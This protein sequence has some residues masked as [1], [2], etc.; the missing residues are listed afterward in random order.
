[1]LSKPQ[2]FDLGLY[3]ICCI[4]L[5]GFACCWFAGIIEL[6]PKPRLNFYLCPSQINFVIIII[7]ILIWNWGLGLRHWKFGIII[8][9][10]GWGLGLGSGIKVDWGIRIGDWM[11]DWVWGLGSR[12]GDWDWIL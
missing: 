3:L 11:G 7:E 10:L 9:D 1:M 2:G 6:R 12:I 5:V 8:G 4:L